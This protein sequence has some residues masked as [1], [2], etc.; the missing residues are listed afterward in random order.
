MAYFSSFVLLFIEYKLWTL[1]LGERE[2]EQWWRDFVLCLHYITLMFH[3][4]SL[5]LNP[6]HMV[7]V[8][9]FV[10]NLLFCILSMIFV[11]RYFT[12]PRCLAVFQI[13]SRF[14]LVLHSHSNSLLITFSRNVD[15]LLLEKSWQLT[16]F[17]ASIKTAINLCLSSVT[18]SNH[19][20]LNIVKETWWDKTKNKKMLTKI[21]NYQMNLYWPI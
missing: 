9:M 21:T 11:Y 19:M 1:C 13:L 5:F 17:S 7:L 16:C 10:Q 2:R 12:M 6:C 14:C 20:H 3:K 4:S 18:S 15:Y 8:I